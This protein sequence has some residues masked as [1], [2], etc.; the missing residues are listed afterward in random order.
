MAR[1]EGTAWGANNYSINIG[2]H[3]EPFLQ[4]RSVEVAHVLAS[5]NGIGLDGYRDFGTSPC[6]RF[7]KLFRPDYCDPS[8][9]SAPEG[10]QK[11]KKLVV[12]T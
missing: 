1:K 9:K 3:R 11:D 8:G 5:E 4:T 7:N 12:K 10:S 6:D 2:F